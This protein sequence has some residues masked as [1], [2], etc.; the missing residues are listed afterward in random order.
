MTGADERARHPEG[1]AFTQFFNTL[2]TGATS[3]CFERKI[4]VDCK[5]QLW[6]AWKFRARE[7]DERRD[8]GFPR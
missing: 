5:E 3:C 8:S 6:S 2:L 4:L 1:R 7:D